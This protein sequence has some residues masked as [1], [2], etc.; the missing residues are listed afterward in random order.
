MLAAAVLTVVI[1]V[2]ARASS[3]TTGLGEPD[4]THF[5]STDCALITKATGYSP[6]TTCQVAPDGASGN[7]M[8]PGANWLPKQAGNGPISAMLSGNLVINSGMLADGD[9]DK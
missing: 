9:A 3:G 1:V 6:R 8:V 2:V 5:P 4:F 7:P